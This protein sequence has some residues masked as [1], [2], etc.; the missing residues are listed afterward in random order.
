M[1]RAEPPPQVVGKLQWRQQHHA[2]AGEAVR[3]EPPLEGLIVLPGRV[4]RVDKKALV[5]IEDVGRHDDD[6]EEGES[7]GARP[8]PCLRLD[9]I[10]H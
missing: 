5:A 2:G 3:Q 8:I 10:K 6:G 9:R 4:R 7:L 1:Q